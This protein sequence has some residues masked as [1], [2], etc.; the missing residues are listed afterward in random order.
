MKDIFNNIEASLKTLGKKLASDFNSVI[1]QVTVDTLGW[2]GLVALQ[3]VTVPSL[4]G[5]MTGL[6]DNT[7]PIDMIIILWAALGL[8]YIKS[9]LERNFVALN[10]IGF[11]FIGQSILMALIFF[12]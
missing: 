4:L 7:P 6:T 8:F 1:K 2:T 3:A 5:L 10:I 9:I 11:G 12:K